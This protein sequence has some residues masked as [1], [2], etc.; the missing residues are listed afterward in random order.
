[1]K[2][3]TDSMVTSALSD[4]SFINVVPEAAALA[5]AA[6]EGHKVSETAKGDSCCGGSKTKARSLFNDFLQLLHG[7][8]HDLQQRIRNYYGED[9]LYT[10]IEGGKHVRK[11]IKAS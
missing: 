3:I 5:Q 4:P 9:L 1:M 6:V 2:L 10:V 7:G 8:D 11:T